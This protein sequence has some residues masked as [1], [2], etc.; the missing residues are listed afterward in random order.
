MFASLCF[1]QELLLVLAPE[2][3]IHIISFLVIAIGCLAAELHL[4]SSYL[5]QQDEPQQ[6]QEEK[7]QEKEGTGKKEQQ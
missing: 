5:G 1:F 3:S 6:E 7:A 4:S 2:C